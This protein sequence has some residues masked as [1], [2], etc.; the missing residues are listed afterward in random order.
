MQYIGIDYKAYSDEEIEEDMHLIREKER[1]YNEKK[2]KERNKIRER[3]KETKNKRNGVICK[4]P[5]SFQELIINNIRQYFLDYDVGHIIEPCGL[6]KSFIAIYYALIGRYNSI[7]IGTPSVPLLSQMRK[8]ILEIL[9]DAIVMIVGGQNNQKIKT[10]ETEMK[11]ARDAK[12]PFF[13][14]S[15][16]ASCCKLK[17]LAFEFK[18]GDECHH[19]TGIESSI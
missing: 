9:P 11:K 16:Y 19:L 14:I 5:K 18:I 8:E 10:I 13:V 6:G 3:I 1:E 12:K 4:D 7:L 2:E 15:T 17:D